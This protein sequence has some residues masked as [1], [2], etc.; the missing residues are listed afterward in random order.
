MAVHQPRHVVL[1]DLFDPV[2]ELH[3]LEDDLKGRRRRRRRGLRRS[4][5]RRRCRRE[6]T[7]RSDDPIFETLQRAARGKPGRGGRLG[8]RKEEAGVD[9][10]VKGRREGDR[11]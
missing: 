6:L 11:G 4:A 8:E 3:R 10:G 7:V 1:D 9:D 2:G 5:D